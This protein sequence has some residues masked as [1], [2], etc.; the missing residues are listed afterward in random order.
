[1]PA[2]DKPIA[3]SAA[4]V[5]PLATATVTGVLPPSS[6]RA[7]AAVTVNLAASSSSTTTAESGAPTL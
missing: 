7:C 5:T 2:A 6:I 1:M 4:N 3:W